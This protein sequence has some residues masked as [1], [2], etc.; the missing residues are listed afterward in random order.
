L[1]ELLA[2]RGWSCGVLSGP[3]VDFERGAD[4]VEVLRTGGVSA[5]SAR[6]E[7]GGL[8]YTLHHALAR[9][10]RLTLYVPENSKPGDPGEAE[11][12]VFLRLFERVCGHFRPDVMLT[13][14]GHWLARETMARAR[15]LGVKI[16]FALHNFAY[17]DATLFQGADAVMLPSRTAQEHYRRTLGIASTP[18]PGPFDDSRILCDSMERRYLTFVNP[19]PEKGVFVFARIAFELGR[20]RPDIPLL[21]VEGRAGSDWLHRVGLGKLGGSNLHTMANTSDP[22]DFYRVSKVVLTPSLVRETL[23]R[24]PAEA[25]LN[26]IPVLASRRGA[27]SETLAETGYLFEVPERYTPESRSV[28]TAEEVRPWLDTV[29]QLWDEPAAY[30]A[31]SQR[32]LAA[33]AAWKPGR[34]LPQFE[35]FFSDVVSGRAQPPFGP[36]IKPDVES[37]CSTKG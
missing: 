14:G 1:L 25:M 31:Q 6:G 12:R 27:L 19:Q 18:L 22:R 17:A 24:V 9:G 2:A 21:V 5:T 34:L 32:C 29:E 23:A 20:R 7:E 33:A 35:T 11:G 37:S 8:G 4:A 13:F 28:P 16:V 15:Q 10:V 30:A 3:Q 26:G 36:G